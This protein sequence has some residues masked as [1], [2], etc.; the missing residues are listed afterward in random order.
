MKMTSRDIDEIMQNSEQGNAVVANWN[1]KPK[2][3]DWNHH[4]TNDHS[5]VRQKFLAKTPCITAG[6]FVFEAISAIRLPSLK[7]LA[8]VM[9]C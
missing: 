4:N 8:E 5:S 7:Y 1:D 9:K 3:N 6:V 2:V